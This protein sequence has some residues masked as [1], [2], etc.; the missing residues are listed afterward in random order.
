MGVHYFFY[1]TGGLQAP[2]FGGSFR[3]S[4]CVDRLFYNEDGT[5]K[6]VLM[7]SEGVQK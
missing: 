7:T 2:N 4:V 3:R 6:R 1:H 5:M